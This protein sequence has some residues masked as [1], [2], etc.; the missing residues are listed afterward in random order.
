MEFT[1][2]IIAVEKRFLKGLF[3]VH[4]RRKKGLLYF[5]FS[6]TFKRLI[7]LRIFLSVYFDCVEIY[8]SPLDNELSVCTFIEL[9]TVLVARTITIAR[10]K[11]KIDLKSNHRVLRLL[12]K[13]CRER[14]IGT[15]RPLAASSGR[16][17]R[18]SNV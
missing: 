9:A 7:K 10:V 8:Q 6:S 11:E 14:T 12:L 2:P 16:Q 18:M 1:N 13:K 4:K 17:I 5:A 3:G 15:E